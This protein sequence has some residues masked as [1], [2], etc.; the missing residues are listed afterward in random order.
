M[1]GYTIPFKSST[2]ED[3]AERSC[4]GENHQ[5]DNNSCC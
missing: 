1:N 5:Q 3:T 4:S 2:V